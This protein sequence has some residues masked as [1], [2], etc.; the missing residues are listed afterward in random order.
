MSEL[1]LQSETSIASDLLAGVK[2]H[3]VISG[4]DEDTRLTQLI[5]S[6]VKF[7]QE[8]TDRD[9][10]QTTWL[11]TMPRFPD[12]IYLKRNPVQSITSIKYYTNDVLTTW[13][14][15]NYRLVNPTSK[16]A[17]IEDVNGW[18]G[19]DSRVDAIQ[20]EYVTGKSTLPDNDVHLINLLCGLWNES[21]EGWS[22]GKQIHFGIEA[23]LEQV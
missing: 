10:M 4:T 5:N 19:H 20:V 14:S 9:L 21:R 8:Q 1:T 2:R 7:I 13:D 23:L 16:A 3:L 12:V 22:M 17:R 15:S 6:V 18:V 11:E